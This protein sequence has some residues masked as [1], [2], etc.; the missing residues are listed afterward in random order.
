M[1]ANPFIRGPKRK[2]GGDN[3]SL[4]GAVSDK[5]TVFLHV[6]APVQ[7]R[8]N[9]RRLWHH[10]KTTRKHMPLPRFPGQNKPK[11]CVFMCF[12][13]QA[14]TTIIY[15]VRDTVTK[16]CKYTVYLFSWWSFLTKEYCFYMRLSLFRIAVC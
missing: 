2:S 8:R 10:V 16:T 11:V 6:F 4:W 15:G 13:Q 3:L 14:A 9:L 7:N 5:R 12:R 1:V